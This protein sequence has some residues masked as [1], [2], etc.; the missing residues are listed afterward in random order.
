[1][2]LLGVR[3]PRGHLKE[4]AKLILQEKKQTN[5]QT[6]KKQNKKKIKTKTNYLLSKCPECA[7]RFVLEVTTFEYS[8]R[9]QNKQR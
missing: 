3:G 2:A 8:R 6:N 5:K 1:M 4:G 7:E 9:A